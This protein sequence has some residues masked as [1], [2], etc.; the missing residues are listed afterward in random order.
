MKIRRLALMSLLGLL[1]A[2]CASAPQ[3]ADYANER[4]QLDLRRYFDGPLLAHGVFT[5]RAGKVQRRFTVRLLGR[6]N[7]NEGVLEEDFDYSD[8]QKQRRVWQ[9]KA[10]G[11]GRYEGRAD[12]V[13]GT[14]QG[15]AAGNALRWSYTLKLPVDGKVYEVDFEDWMYLVDEQVMLNKAKMS[16]FGWHLGDVTLS[17]QRP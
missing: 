14:A 3:P 5:D 11:N 9:L 6:W 12:D 2:S 7:G 8:G 1:L 16:K 13:V 15:E 4:P 10:L 17:F